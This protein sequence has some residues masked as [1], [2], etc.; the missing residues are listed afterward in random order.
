MEGTGRQDKARVAAPLLRRAPIRARMPAPRPP[1]DAPTC[2]ETLMILVSEPVK[3]WS[4]ALLML[5]GLAL[6]GC[7]GVELDEPTAP[8]AETPLATQRAA[9]YSEAD[10]D[11]PNDCPVPER[12]VD[13]GP[14]RPQA[15]TWRTSDGGYCTTRDA[16]GRDLYV[17]PF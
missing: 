3:S 6:V 8:G 1:L 17:C 5:G 16:C 13:C 7:G 15:Y 12:Y 14:G 9:E 4:R 2:L 11:G 10:C